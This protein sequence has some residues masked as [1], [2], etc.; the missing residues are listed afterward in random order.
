MEKYMF[1]FRHTE[2]AQIIEF[3]FPIIQRRVHSI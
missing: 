3:H 2:I 1:S